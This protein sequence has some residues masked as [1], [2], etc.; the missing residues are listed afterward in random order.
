MN[1]TPENSVIVQE[2]YNSNEEQ[3]VRTENDY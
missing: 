1:S 2:E 3:E